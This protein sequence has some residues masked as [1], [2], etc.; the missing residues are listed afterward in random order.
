MKYSV[1]LMLYTHQANTK[2]QYP[3]YCRITINRKQSYLSTGHFIDKQYWDEKN[4]RVK[5][6]HLQ[7]HTINPDITSCKQ[8]IIKI[9]VAHQVKGKTITAAALKELVTSKTDLHNIFEFA[10]LFVNEVQH[11]REASTLENYRKH[12]KVVELY[13]GSRSL[14]FEEITHD[15]LVK[16]EDHLRKPVTGGRAALGGNYIHVIWKTLKTFF[17]AAIKRKVISH[18]PFDTYEN[19]EYEAPDK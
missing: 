11:K 15:W 5:S 9:I 19:P 1:K 16:F 17:N 3:I 8:A 2:G 12:M 14:T 4:E 7:A 10:D 13:H 6:G 18:Y